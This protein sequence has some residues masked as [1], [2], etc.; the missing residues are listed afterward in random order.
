MVVSLHFVKVECRS[1]CCSV[2]IRSPPRNE[3]IFGRFPEFG[4]RVQSLN[5]RN[6]VGKPFITAADNVHCTKIVARAGRCRREWRKYATYFEGLLT[7]LHKS[8]TEHQESELLAGQIIRD[9][10]GNDRRD[11]R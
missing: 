9:I 11:G 7:S 1:F 4:C 10:G 6:A 8:N 5:V 2:T 3:S